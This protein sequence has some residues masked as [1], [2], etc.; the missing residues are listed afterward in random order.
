[1]YRSST[2]RGVPTEAARISRGAYDSEEVTRGGMQ[3]P[4]CAPFGV[5][6]MRFHEDSSSAELTRAG[7]NHRSPSN[8]PTLRFHRVA[9]GETLTQ[10]AE[11]HYGDES[12]W[13]LLYGANEKVI[14]EAGRLRWGLILYVPF[15]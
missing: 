8:A 6:V 3:S 13:V 2:Q 10:I 7:V 14:R 15:V 4:D 5:D 9:P 1:M 11:Q 12:F